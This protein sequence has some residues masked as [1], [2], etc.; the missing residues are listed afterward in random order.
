MYGAPPEIHAPHHAHGLDR[1]GEVGHHSQ[2]QS[3]DPSCVAERPHD[4]SLPPAR[5]HHRR[6]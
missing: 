4:N 6:V 2:R 1:V 3:E 5:C